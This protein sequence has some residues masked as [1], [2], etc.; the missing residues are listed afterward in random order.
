MSKKDV[1]ISSLTLKILCLPVFTISVY[2]HL[3]LVVTLTKNFT[4]LFFHTPNPVCQ[5]IL[6]IFK[7]YLKADHF[8]PPRLR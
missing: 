6:S 1:I 4:L 3:V 5:E 2:G 7:A 8:L